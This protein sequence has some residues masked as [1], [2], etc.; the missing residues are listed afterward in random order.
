MDR[1]I[2]LVTIQYRLGTLGLLAAGTRDYPGNAALKDQVLAL[3]WVRDH[4]EH[5]G[6]DAGDVTLM[7]YSTGGWSVSLHMVSP[8]SAGLF[9]KAIVMSGAATGQ[10][11]MPGE[12]LAVARRQARLLDCAGAEEEEESVDEMIAC[13]QTVN[14]T[15][16]GQTLPDMFEFGHGNPLLLWS[17]VV[18][19]DFGQERF[20]TDDP[21]RLFRSGRFQR[22]PILAGIT[23]LEFMTP[24]VGKTHTKQTYLWYCKSI[25]LLSF[26]TDIIRNP[27]LRFEMDTNF[28]Q[29]API[30]F[31]Y[32]RGTERSKDISQ[33]LRKDFLN[34]PLLDERS[35]PGLA[36]VI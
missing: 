27:L 13:M 1:D 18:E 20:L 3:R 19:P 31:L 6:G 22:V 34:A 24:A 10:W 16:F 33:S 15:F 21:V 7:G 11:S 12:Q 26:C 32:E 14:A 4:I 17:P 28:S 23:E 25:K 36:D 2:V 9:H 29:I 5:F 8:M 35:I 30:C